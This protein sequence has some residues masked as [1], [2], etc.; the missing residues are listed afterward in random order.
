MSPV[1]PKPAAEFST[2]AMTKS[3]AVALDQRGNR[4]PR[5]LAAGLAEDVA[6][7]QDAHRL[8]SRRLRRADRD[9]DLLTA[10]FVDARHDDAE[11]AGGERRLGPA[12]VESASKPDRTREA[13]EA[14]LGQVKRGLALVLTARGPLV[15]RRSRRCR[16]DR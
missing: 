9:G 4:A 14:A 11:L 5:D 8:S 16:P 15:P 2:L 10:P 1:T 6:D 12:R 7:E 3:S 13:P